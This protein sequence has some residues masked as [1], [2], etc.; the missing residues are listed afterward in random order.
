[1][2]TAV[3][4]PYKPSEAEILRKNILLFN[5]NLL[6]DFGAVLKGFEDVFGFN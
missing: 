5:K 2:P 4:T 3:T 1:M 6:V